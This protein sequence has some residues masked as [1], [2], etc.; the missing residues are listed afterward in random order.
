[1]ATN[2]AGAVRNG[3]MAA[4]RL[5]VEFD[6]K[7]KMQRQGGSIDVFD[8]VLGANL[9]LLLRPLR[10]LL[11]AYLP[12]PIPGILVT[13]ERPLSIQ[14]FTAAHELGH[15]RL[16]HRPSLDDET[17][18]R[19]MTMSAVPTAADPD[20]QEVEADAFA[21]G[22]LMPR[23]LIGWH[24]HRQGWFAPDLTK[25]HVAY[26]LSLR[27]GAS[28]EALS[29]TLQRYN[30]I[31]GVAGQTL[32]QTQPRRVKVDLLDEH[33]PHDY[34]GDVW[35]LT[36]RDADT[37]IDG[38]RNDHFVLRLNEHSGGGYL[39][40]IDQLQ[41]S[42]FAIIRDGR[43]SNDSEGIGGPVVRHVT[44]A[45]ERGQRGRLS[46]D[47]RRPWQPNAPISHV[48]LNYDFMGP[49]EEGFSRAERRQLLEAA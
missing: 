33:R 36:E 10:G 37:R 9:P 23:W 49:E 3:S 12:D 32:R 45:L 31:S 29:W 15:F 6:T 21:V 16:K 1:M 26:Q 43:E 4:A 19:R 7:A 24:C 30:L 35:V 11:G 44:V 13:T 48:T 20:M 46:L 47:E 5:H 22:F 34:R 17:L 28:Y 42:G 25:P 27:L 8:A 41:E 14:R 18:L 2:Y 39:W 40:N 38:S